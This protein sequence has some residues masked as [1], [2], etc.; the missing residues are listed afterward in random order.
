MA[1]RTRL[2]ADAVALATRSLITGE[3]IA[4][5]KAN[6]G[7]KNL[8]FDLLALSGLLRQS[9]SN[10]VGKTAV[11]T[12]DLDQADLLCDQMLNAV[13]TRE[14]APVIASEASSQRQRHFTL[15]VTAYDQVRRAISYL[16]WDENDLEQIA[17]SLYVA[18][19]ASGKRKTQ[20]PEAA[21]PPEPPVAA[22][23]PVD[24][25]HVTA[26]PVETPAAA[27]AAHPVASVAPG[28]PGSSPLA[29][30]A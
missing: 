8:A 19:R 24:A 30:L 23:A 16:R 17:P 13:G 20:S 18:G 26:T 12:A 22:P 1:L 11:T 15:F 14:Q 6:I 29:N 4:E 2:Y 9:W 28:L 27:K 10:I 5:F 3:R 7:Y 21:P 25:P